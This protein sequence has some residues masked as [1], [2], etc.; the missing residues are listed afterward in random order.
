MRIRVVDRGHGMTREVQQRIGRPYFSTR[1]GGSGLGIAVARAMV[2]QHGG[3]LRFD[4]APGEGT[5][6]TIEI[7][8]VAAPPERESLPSPKATTGSAPAGVKLVG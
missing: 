1:E 7:P 2:E 8:L 4:S 6:A 5:T 3:V